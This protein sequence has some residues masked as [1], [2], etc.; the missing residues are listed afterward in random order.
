MATTR[1]SRAVAG[2]ITSFLEYALVMALQFALVP[3]V[4]RIAGQEVLGAYSFLMQMVSW[5]A[6]TD[7][8]FGVA[9]GRNLAQAYGMDDQRKRFCTVFI[10]GRTFYLASNVA[11]AVL[12]LIIGWKVNSLMSMSYSVESQARLSLFLLAIW[13]AIR[14]PVSLYGNALIATQNLA[15]VNAIAAMGSAL[16]LLLSL[17]LVALGAG[18]IGL[19][20]ANVVAEAIT[21]I[22]QRAWYR[23]LYPDDQFG[24]GIPDR[25]LFREMLGFGLTYMVMIVASRLSANTDSIIV[26]YLQGAAAVSVYYTS[27]MPGTILY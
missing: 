1:T 4:L 18:L 20:S 7:L 9:T 12:V 26:G 16:R 23:K 14:T 21:F 11:F 27:Q 5:A 22:I 10:T 3:V 2:T 6:L 8:G 13:I 19:M 25:A 15:A 17:G 24:W